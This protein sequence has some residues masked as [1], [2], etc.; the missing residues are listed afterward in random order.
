MPHRG[1][2]IGSGGAESAPADR[3][4]PDRLASFLSFLRSVSP[5]PSEELPPVEA[6]EQTPATGS[7][8]SATTRDTKPE[9]SAAGATPQAA[10][11]RA[12]DSSPVVRPPGALPTLAATSVARVIEAPAVAPTAPAETAPGETAPAETAAGTAQM[13]TSAPRAATEPSGVE[14]AELAPP[15][16]A[17][18][19]VVSPVAGPAGVA[20]GEAVPAVVEPPAVTSAVVAPAVVD[21][22]KARPADSKKGRHRSPRSGRFGIRGIAFTTRR[23]FILGVLTAAVVAAVVLALM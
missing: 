4:T 11:P 10:E 19:E 14:V 1:W 13:A 18:T 12:A 17:P 16:V 5:D 8:T 6:S 7:A 22:H 21:R 9:G 20:P 2:R 15:V 23:L 3:L